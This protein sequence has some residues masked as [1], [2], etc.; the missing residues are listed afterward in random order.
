MMHISMARNS[1]KQ[2]SLYKT[3]SAIL[4]GVLIG[5]SACQHGMPAPVT[6]D[7]LVSKYLNL[8]VELGERDPDSLDFYV[9]PP[10]IVESVKTHPEKL[11]RLHDNAVLLRHQL[12]SYTG[13]ATF[14][15]A[16]K[17][18][19]AKQ[20]DA[21]I[22]RTEQ[23]RGS[24]HSF[25]TESRILFGVVAPPDMDVSERKAIRAKLFV[26]LGNPP[27]LAQAYAKYDRQFVI[28]SESVPA[29][30][31]VALRECRELTL[32]HMTLPQ[33]EH[34][35]VEYVFHKPWSAFSRYL[36][37]AHSLI[38]VNMDY[39]IT[40]DRLLDLA[41]HEGYPGHHVFNSIRDRALVREQHREEFSAQPTFSPQ[42]Y[43]SEAAA[44]Y[45]PNLALSNAER[46]RI[47][48]DVLFPLAK[49]KGLDAKRYIEVQQLIAALHTAEPSIARE[50]LDGRLEFVRAAD[51]LE[52]ETLM[53]HG[54]TILLYLNEYRIY[55]LSY[56]VGRDSVRALMEQGHP[57]DAL[58][59]VRYRSL[60]TNDVVSLPAPGKK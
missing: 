49:L 50:Y 15:I 34:V 44:S 43:V 7:D 11:D 55:M 21:L 25:D 12:A 5:L 9:G 47:E 8:V 52:R 16:R 46:L 23:L 20:L 42:S 60:I 18:F 6:V 59:W 54:E 31:N 56:T 53:E 30:M 22:L 29:A 3:A 17:S 2:L 26:L 14:D 35:D 36:G 51:A 38:Q 48:Q 1:P 27:N 41:C 58:R 24:N 19:L 4:L 28:P 45:A 32:Q 37:D 13:S 10:D 33:G 57:T 40:V 39:P